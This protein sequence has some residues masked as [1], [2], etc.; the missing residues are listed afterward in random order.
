VKRLTLFENA[1]RG[2]IPV[3]IGNLVN[4]RFLELN[5]NALTG[6]IPASIGN[7]INLKYLELSRNSLTGSI[8]AS[9]SDLA[10]LD[11]GLYLDS[12]ALTGSIPD[13]FCDLHYLS[14]R[15]DCSICEHSSPACCTAAIC[16]YEMSVM[17]R[18]I[19]VLMVLL[20]MMIL[21][22]LHA[23]GKN[24]K[25]NETLEEEVGDVEVIPIVEIS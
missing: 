16:G 18:M 6:S 11:I 25:R 19:L 21:N 23:R 17:A 24:R 8:P 20:V 9:I 1:L 15:A 14:L 22:P 10:N 4:L 12:N 3:S 7:L 13:E 2:S 5:H